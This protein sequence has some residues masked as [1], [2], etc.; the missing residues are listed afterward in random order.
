M[1]W[2]NKWSNETGTLM[3]TAAA[4]SACAEAPS[5]L[6][7][8]PPNPDYYRHGRQTAIHVHSMML[9]NDPGEVDEINEPSTP[10]ELVSWLI[11]FSTVDTDNAEDAPTMVS[12]QKS[13]ESSGMSTIEEG[14]LM[15]A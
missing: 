10:H 7:D 13:L 14:R 12:R 4:R 5:E 2:F 1:D 8:T 3:S 9:G 11:G 6:L 15:N